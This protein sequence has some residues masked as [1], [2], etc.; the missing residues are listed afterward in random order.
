VQL[1]DLAERLID[2]GLVGGA[3]EYFGL[4]S[5]VLL[6]LLLLDREREHLL[7]P[8]LVE[9]RF[10]IVGA[11]AF[12]IATIPKFLVQNRPTTAG[13]MS[14]VGGVSVPEAY[15]NQ[16]NSLGFFKESCDGRLEPVSDPLLLSPSAM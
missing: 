15:P 11:L 8:L 3:G 13:V 14:L 12:N 9:V 6:V 1:L 16:P 7:K 2:S 5:S 4:P 10:W